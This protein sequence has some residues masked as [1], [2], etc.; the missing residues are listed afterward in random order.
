METGDVLHAESF[1]L[2]K[3]DR[4]EERTLLIEKVI[5]ALIPGQA[6]VT[7]LMMFQT[8]IMTGRMNIR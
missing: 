5:Y 1:L 2:I 4:L 8:G 6:A 7:I 3:K